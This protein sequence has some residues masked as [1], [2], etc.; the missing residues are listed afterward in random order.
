MPRNQGVI[1][2]PGAYAGLLRRIFAVAIDLCVIPILWTVVS[3]TAFFLL[4]VD[5]LTDGIS[6]ASYFFVVWLYL[7]VMKPSR[8]RSVGYW[9]TGLKIVDYQGRRPSI[10]RM[11]AR[12]LFTFVGP[13]T[14][15][16]DT[17][18]LAAD[19][20]RQSLHDK[21]AGT[22]VVRKDAVPIGTGH[23]RAAY[24]D[25]ACWMLLLWDLVPDDASSSV[26]PSSVDA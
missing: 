18:W 13:M 25:C 16:Y 6:G 23:R 14:V 26:R 9:L 2:A 11:T 10:A 22:F 19:P 8:F 15:W 1:Y 24:Y 17:I 20:H 4:P 7:T 21:A 3:F 5:L 12:L